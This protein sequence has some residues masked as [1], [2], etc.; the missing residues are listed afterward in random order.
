MDPSYG[1]AVEVFVDA[2]MYSI[3]VGSDEN[4]QAKIM[5]ARIY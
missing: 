3:N 5:W 1:S 2:N 4:Y